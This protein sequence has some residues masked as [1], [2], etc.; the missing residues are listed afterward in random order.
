VFAVVDLLPAL[1]GGQAGGWVVGLDAVAEP[2]RAARGAG[3]EAEFGTVARGCHDR[4][5]VVRAAL[6]V[7][8][9]TEG[10]RVSLSA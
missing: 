5:R 4:T 10:A 7:R 1:F 3:Q 8:D 9:I 6:G 2:V